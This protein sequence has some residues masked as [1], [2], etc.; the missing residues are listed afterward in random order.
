MKNI[1]KK[2]STRLSLAF[3]NDGNYHHVKGFI[4]MSIGK[5]EVA[6]LKK[7]NKD[8]GA[9]EVYCPAYKNYLQ[10]RLTDLQGSTFAHD[11]KVRIY[12]EDVGYTH[13]I[14]ML[15]RASSKVNKLGISGK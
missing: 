6:I 1:V 14:K 5:W 7:L 3:G 9:F 4:N 2:S 15:T 10:G 12:L 11:E 13:R 8:T